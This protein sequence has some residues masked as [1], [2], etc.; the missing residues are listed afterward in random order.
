MF[1]LS[2]LKAAWS[3]DVIPLYL[4]FIISLP[5]GILLLSFE[6]GGIFVRKSSKHLIHCFD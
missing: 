3:V 2:L 4:H 5:I 1:F 6:D